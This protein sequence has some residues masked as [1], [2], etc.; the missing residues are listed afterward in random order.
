[1]AERTPP[2]GLR[3]SSLQPEPHQARL[4][5]NKRRTTGKAESQAKNTGKKEETPNQRL[6]VGQMRISKCARSRLTKPKG[7]TFQRSLKMDGR[8][9]TNRLS[10]EFHDYWWFRFAIINM[11]LNQEKVKPD[12]HAG[13][14]SDAIIKAVG[15]SRTKS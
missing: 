7:K 14:I 12:P 10:L 3:R 13:W 15:A 8:F 6:T 2:F 11:I 9:A 4:L 5:L 1:M